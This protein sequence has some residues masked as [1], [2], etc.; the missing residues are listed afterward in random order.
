L[1]EPELITTFLVTLQDGAGA[2]IERFEAVRV[3]ASLE[4]SR[5]AAADDTAASESHPGN[6]PLE[7]L[8]QL[9]ASWWKEGRDLAE[10]EVL[11]RGAAWKQSL[12]AFRGLDRETRRPEIDRWD[13]AT[14]RAI[15]GDYE[16]QVEQGRL[17]G[18]QPNIPPAIRRRLEDHR[19]RA[20]FQRSLLERR[21]SFGELALEPLGMLLRI[22]ASLAEVR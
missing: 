22:P 4:V 18:G 17:F 10:Q 11:R 19:K 6:V 7:L 8:E 21:M 2:V 5:D 13:E 15:L 3:S 16:R 1:V 14:K 12:I 20:D 9:F